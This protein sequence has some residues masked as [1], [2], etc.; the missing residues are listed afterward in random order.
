MSYIYLFLK[1]G[2]HQSLLIAEYQ[3][4]FDEAG[5]LKFQEILKKLCLQIT[6][7]EFSDPEE[8][9]TNDIYNDVFYAFKNKRNLNNIWFSQGHQATPLIRGLDDLVFII[10]RALKKI[11]KDHDIFC[12]DVMEMISD[13]REP[14]IQNEESEGDLVMKTNEYTRQ[15]KKCQEK[16]EQIMEKMNQMKKLKQSIKVEEKELEMFIQRK[17]KIKHSFRYF[18]Y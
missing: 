15:I 6:E 5:R 12:T 8:F 17:V 9:E 3:I 13:L 18:L 10:V 4:N 7:V 1:Q 16:I 2:L 14:V 11:T